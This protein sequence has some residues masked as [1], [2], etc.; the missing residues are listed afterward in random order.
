MNEYQHFEYFVLVSD[1][2]GHDYAVPPEKV[3]EVE[4]IFEKDWDNWS[5]SEQELI[6]S[7]TQ[8][9]GDDYFIVLKSDVHH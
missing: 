7:L 1:G 9:E 3:G 2:D 5:E 6:D 4:S 8:I